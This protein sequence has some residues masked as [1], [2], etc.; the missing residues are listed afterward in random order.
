M[1]QAAAGLFFKMPHQ[2]SASPLPGWIDD[3]GGPF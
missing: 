3:D 1:L 2:S